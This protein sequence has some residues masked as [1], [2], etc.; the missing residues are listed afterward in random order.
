MPEKALIEQMKLLVS[1]FLAYSPIAFAPSELLGHILL[2][3]NA[4]LIFM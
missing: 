3:T 2:N 4:E 1:L